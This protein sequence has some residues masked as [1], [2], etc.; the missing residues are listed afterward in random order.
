MRVADTD[1]LLKA[2]IRLARA[3]AFD[4]ILLILE[5]PTAALSPEQTRSYASIIRNVGTG[6]KATLMGLTADEKFAEHT[7]GRLLVWQPATGEFRERSSRKFW[8]F[9]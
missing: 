2:C 4:P 9:S 7:N 3:L 1:P 8:P 5:H 6:R